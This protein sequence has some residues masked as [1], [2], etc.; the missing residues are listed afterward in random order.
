MKNIKQLTVLIGAFCLLVFNVDLL[1]Q[2]VSPVHRDN[3]PQFIDEMES[4][5]DTLIKIPLPVISSYLLNHLDHN[6]IPCDAPDSLQVT[7]M[8]DSTLSIKWLPVDSAV[9]YRVG[10]FNLVTGDNAELIVPA[11][12]TDHDFYPIPNGFFMVWV[13]AKCGEGMFGPMSIIIIDKVVQMSLDLGISCKCDLPEIFLN[14]GTYAISGPMNGY[15][16]FKINLYSDGQLSYSLSFKLILAS[17]VPTY[18]VNPTCFSPGV[19]MQN[20]LGYVPGGPGNLHFQNESGEVK[21]T[22]NQSTYALKLVTC[23]PIIPLPRSSENS[24]I[25]TIDHSF[26]AYPNPF[27]DRLS[28]AFTDGETSPKLTIHDALG[29]AWVQGIATNNM[30]D[31]SMLPPGIYFLTLE[32]DDWKKTE[33]IIK[34]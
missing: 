3:L 2:P 12:A 10:Y 31:V 13:Q 17:G 6:N 33:K 15:Q 16:G 7:G 4:Y 9:N 20:G 28:L 30:V 5:Y 14:V 24:N 32:T 25:E 27:F 34:L 29:K 23:G 11:T 26:A 22:N 19:T 18:H 1:A 8:T 21:V